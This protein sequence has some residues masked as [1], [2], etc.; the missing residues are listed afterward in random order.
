MASAS[1]RPAP[2]VAPP[3]R[4]RRARRSSARARSGASA[5]T[6]A[7]TDSDAATSRDDAW[8]LRDGRFLWRGHDVHF[9]RA[10]DPARATKHVVFL[11]GFGVGTFHY[12]AQLRDL[13][14]ATTCVWALDL[15]GQGDSWPAPGACVDG[16]AY[17]AETWRDQVIH[18]LERVVREEAAANDATAEPTRA[19]L[20]GNSLGGFVAAHVAAEAPALVKGL[21]LMNATPFWAFV[22][23][24][25]EDEDEDEHASNFPRPSLVPW[26]GQLPAPRWIQAPFRW[27]WDS[28]RSEA[29]VRGLLS[30]V[31]ARPDAVDASLVRD[32]VA[33]TNRPDALAAF[34]SVVWS[35]KPRRSFDEV[36]A[37]LAR[38]DECRHIPVSLVYGR[39]D[40]WVV[41]LWGQ[42]LKRAVPRAWYYQLS[43][44]GH[45][46][47]H[48]SPAAVNDVV[49]GWVEWAEGAGAGGEEREPPAGSECG[50]ARLVDGAPGNVFE[51][52]AAWWETRAG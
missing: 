48:E 46:P 12:D 47:A 44:V 43:D 24:R 31:Y 18:F 19:Y 22:P 5:S 32:I 41:P 16:F 26:R 50:V 35:P 23:P 2:P 49:A 52:L 13:P 27:Y 11:H 29:N 34:C 17:S 33:P 3:L 36:L 14:D 1:A 20:A 15:V 38:S 25:D 6:T 51:R 39:D 8:R 45:C 4:A 37:R 40:P 10:G 28:F 21:I 9:E 42:R 7:S 30:L